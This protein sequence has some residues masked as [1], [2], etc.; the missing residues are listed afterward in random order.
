MVIG[1]EVVGGTVITN[2]R[3]A[4]KKEKVWPHTC[5]MALSPVQYSFFKHWHMNII[6]LRSFTT[7]TVF[8]SSDPPLNKEH[9]LL[10]Q[11]SQLVSYYTP[12]RGNSFAGR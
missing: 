3:E 8:I 6:H 1:G 5:E 4:K 2:L 7:F 9:L 10:P 11:V 12:G